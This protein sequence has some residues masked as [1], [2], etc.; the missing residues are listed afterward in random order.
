MGM[1][2]ELLT[3]EQLSSLGKRL[4][5]VRE[6]LG[7]KQNEMAEILEF[8][9]SYIS[10]IEK[11]KNN[12]GFKILILLYMKYKVSMDWLVFNEGEMFCGT[13]IKDKG[14]LKDFEF[15]D[16]TDRVFEM[17]EIMDKSPFFLS[18]MMSQYLK[19]YYEYE[20]VITKDINRNKPQKKQD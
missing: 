6:S 15:C 19:Y 11:G 13:K 4:K 12:P 3:K 9:P 16:Q 18:Y 1:K 20:S 2:E 14:T 5:A 8:S 7:L 17:L 10:D